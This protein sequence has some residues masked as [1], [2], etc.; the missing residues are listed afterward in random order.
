MGLRTQHFK[1]H[2][3]I[4]QLGL[5]FYNIYWEW[6][7]RSSSQALLVGHS[8][9]FAP[10]RKDSALSQAQNPSRAH[11]HPQP[12]PRD[13]AQLEQPA[14]PW[15]KGRG[16]SLVDV[17]VG[18]VGENVVLSPEDL[19]GLLG[20]FLQLRHN[21]EKR[22]FKTLLLLLHRQ[23]SLIWWCSRSPRRGTHHTW[24]NLCV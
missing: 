8:G 4:L 14:G 1:L 24:R 5:R 10:G 23:I 6:E 7:Q 21:Q 16:D 17:G 20:I 22:L 11:A 9:R 2:I 12:S 19:H 18:V 3:S 13:G 15:I